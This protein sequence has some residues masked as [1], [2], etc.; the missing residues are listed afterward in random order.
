MGS[1][2][3]ME[4]EHEAEIELEDALN[5]PSL[6]AEERKVIEDQLAMISSKYKDMVNELLA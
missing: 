4:R 6:S 2:Y 5:D 1:L 3:A